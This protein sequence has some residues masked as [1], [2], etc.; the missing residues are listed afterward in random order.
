M[1]GLGKILVLLGYGL[2]TVALAGSLGLGSS[3]GTSNPR[4]T[5]N[6]NEPGHDG[7]PADYSAINETNDAAINTYANSNTLNNFYATQQPNY[8]AC[9]AAA[10]SG[11]KCNSPD[12][13]TPDQMPA[14]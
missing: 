7:S 12:M 6:K 14:T 8:D 9:I 1:S 3:G 2:G 4:S 13:V 10:S 11:G 5:P